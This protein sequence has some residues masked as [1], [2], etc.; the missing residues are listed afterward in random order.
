MESTKPVDHAYLRDRIETEGVQDDITYYFRV[1]RSRLDQF[2]AASDWLFHLTTLDGS[3]RVVLEALVSGLPV[4]G[5][6]HPGVTVLDPDDE[7]ILFA[8]PFDPDTLLDQLLA[9]KA[10]NTGH[11]ERAEK[12]RNH[13]MKYHSSEAVS[14]QYIEL[15]SRLLAAQ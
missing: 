4:I 1:D 3:P 11:T 6:R 2:Y 14:A 9:E 5:S 7:F 15:Y 12:G 8:D 13:M 10:E